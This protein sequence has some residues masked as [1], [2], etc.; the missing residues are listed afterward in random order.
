ML[1][2]LAIAT[3]LVLP[4]PSQPVV[5]VSPQIHVD[6]V[7]YLPAAAKIAVVAA[8]APTRFVLRR[9]AGDAVVFRGTLSPARLDPSS[10]DTTRLAD[11]SR[12]TAPGEYYLEVPGLGRSY[13]F[14]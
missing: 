14:R 10:G 11:F 8:A 5:K 9:A 6:Q 13:T 7:G 1:R 2:M 4:G 3:A 12:V